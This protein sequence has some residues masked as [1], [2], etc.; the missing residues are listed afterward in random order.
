MIEGAIWEKQAKRGDLCFRCLPGIRDCMVLRHFFVLLMI[1]L[2][3]VQDSGD[4]EAAF[5]GTEDDD[6][7]DKTL[8]VERFGDLIS[9][10]ALRDQEKQGRSY[11]E[12]D[13]ECR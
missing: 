4:D 1:L 12:T 8:G 5:P 7:L 10:S 2:T 13:F 9:K 3:D 11:S 6:E